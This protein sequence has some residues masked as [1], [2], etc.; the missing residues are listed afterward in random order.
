MSKQKSPDISVRA[1][2]YVGVPGFEPGT[3]WSQTRCATGLR[4]TPNLFPE[5]KIFSDPEL[6]LFKSLLFSMAVREGFEPSVPFYQY[7][8][9]A[10]CWFQPLI[11]LT[12]SKK[13]CPFFRRTAKIE[14]YTNSQTSQKEKTLR[15]IRG[16]FPWGISLVKK[17]SFEFSS[18]CRL[19]L[20]GIPD[21][22]Q[23]NFERLD[24]NELRWSDLCHQNA[25]R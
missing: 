23:L 8:S 24:R 18:V 15:N 17:Y 22:C 9:L 25:Y 16:F 13:R 10:N 19:P 21:R 4:Y 11:H 5:L 1:F 2:N 12:F 14:I 3:P 6:Y 7:G 20:R